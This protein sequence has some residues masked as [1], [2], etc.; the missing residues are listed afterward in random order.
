MGVYVGGGSGSGD[1]HIPQ[2]ISGKTKSGGTL[3]LKTTKAVKK[4]TK[5]VTKKKAK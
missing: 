2:A 1:T 5:K 3:P 4:T